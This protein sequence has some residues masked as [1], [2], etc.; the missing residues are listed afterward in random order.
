MLNLCPPLLSRSCRVA[1]RDRHYSSGAKVYCKKKKNHFVTADVF[2]SVQVGALVN[3]DVWIYGSGA[4][5]RSSKCAMITV[6]SVGKRFPPLLLK[7]GYSN[8][9]IK[10]NNPS[11]S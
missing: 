9:Q 6:G 3:V 8:L 4:A 1:L 7:P 10:V 2:G 11:C 5:T